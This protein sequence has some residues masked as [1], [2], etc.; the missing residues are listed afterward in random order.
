MDFSSTWDALVE[1]AHRVVLAVIGD[2]T[3]ALEKN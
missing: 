3:G 1:A 2:N